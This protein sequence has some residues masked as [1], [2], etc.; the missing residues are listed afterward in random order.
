MDHFISTQ[1]LE[2][3]CYIKNKY[4]KKNISSQISI[5]TVI[6]MCYTGYHLMNLKS[7]K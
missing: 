7:H 4:F 3:K 1:L 2:K 5:D 6:K